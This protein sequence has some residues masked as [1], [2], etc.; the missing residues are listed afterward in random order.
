MLERGRGKIVFVASLLSFQGGITVPG[1]AASKGGV[2]QLTKA[3]A[4]EWAARGVN[5]NAVAPG[6]IATDNTQALQ[7]DP[8][9]SASDPRPDPGRA[10]G[11]GGG[12]RRGGALPRLARSRLRARRGS[13][14]GRGMAGAMSGLAGLLEQRVVPVVVVHDAADR[15][16]DGGS[17]GEGWPAGGGDHLPHRRGRRGDSRDRRRDQRSRRRRHGRPAGAGGR[18]CRGGRAVRGDSRPQHPG[19][20]A[21][22]GAGRSGRARRRDGDRGDRGARPGARAPQVLPGRSGRRRRGAEGARRPLSRRAL[23]RDRRHRC[24]ERRVVPCAPVRRRRRRQLDGGSRSDRRG[25]L[26]GR[27]PTRARG[28]RPGGVRDDERAHAARGRGVRLRPRLAR[29]DHAAARSGR[30]ADPQ[31]PAVPRLG[32]RRAST[33]WPA[34]CAAASGCGRP[35]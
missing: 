7:D 18:G 4:N 32:G 27:H 26:P 22:P 19:G 29:R 11:D 34:A 1:Y 25:G 33:T 8:V 24:G 5:V 28:R 10:L 15:R 2:A 9:R 31:R 21:L 20:G 16:T 23:D 13:P 14:R 3:L 17:A 12:H 30:G 35:S 6:Y